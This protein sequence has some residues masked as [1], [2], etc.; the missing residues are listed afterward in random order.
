MEP[1]CLIAPDTDW[2]YGGKPVYVSACRV[3]WSFLNFFDDWKRGGWRIQSNKDTHLPTISK[4]CTSSQFQFTSSTKI[5]LKSSNFLRYLFFPQWKKKKICLWYNGSRCACNTYFF[6]T[7]AHSFF[8]VIMLYF[9]HQ[10]YS[11]DFI[12]NKGLTEELWEKKAYMWTAVPPFISDCFTR[13]YYKIISLVCI[14]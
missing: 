10:G 9:P 8:H 14:P 13:P 11:W 6:W 7:T 5:I 3:H 1:L 4:S 2:A 12:S